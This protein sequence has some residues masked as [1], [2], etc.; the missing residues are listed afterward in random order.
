VIERHTTTFVLDASATYDPDNGPTPLVYDWSV[1]TDDEWADIA[2]QTP[3]EMVTNV[4][5]LPPG[6]YHFD[7]RVFDGGHVRSVSVWVTV[8]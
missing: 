7:L 8:Q 2:I 3:N 1:I 5:G 4:T 6:V